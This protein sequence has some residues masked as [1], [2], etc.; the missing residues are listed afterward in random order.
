M[1]KK[2]LVLAALALGSTVALADDHAEKKDTSKQTYVTA[3]YAMPDVT[4]FSGGSAVVLTYGMPQEYEVPNG[5]IAFE[6]E[7]STTLSSP[8]VSSFWGTLEVSYLTLAGYAVYNYPVNEEITLRARGGLLYE[9]IEVSGGGASASDTDF[10]LSYGFG[11]T[12]KINEKM[13]AIA[14]Y[15]MI[16]ADI[17]HMSFGVQYKY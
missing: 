4:G 3:Q 8:D 5:N 9:D 16:E 2:T 15:T 13:N 10:G 7:L 17:S 14:E 1:F 12:Y 6:A 11:G